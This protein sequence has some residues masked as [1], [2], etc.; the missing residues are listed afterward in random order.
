MLISVPEAYSSSAT[1]PYTAVRPSAAMPSSSTLFLTTTPC[2]AQPLQLLGQTTTSHP[3]LLR[4]ANQLVTDPLRS[5]AVCVYRP[6]PM[7]A[8]YGTLSQMGSKDKGRK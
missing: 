5:I 4:P 8:N 1:I 6:S 3:L 7:N 2:S